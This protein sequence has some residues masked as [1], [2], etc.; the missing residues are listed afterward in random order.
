MKD[1]ILVVALSLTAMA[2]VGKYVRPTTQDRV[3]STPEFIARGGYLVNSVSSCG[4]CHT[5]RIG[6]NWLGGERT[7]AF[8]AGG[9]VFDDR[10]MGMKIAAPNITQDNETGIG[11]WT[12]DEIIRGIRD[13]VRKDGELMWPPMPFSADGFGAMSDDDVRAMVAYLRTV[14]P[15]KNKVDRDKHLDMPFMFKVVRSFG[16]L[17]HK[18]A[19]DVK[20]PP[21]A[22]KKAYGAYLSRVGLCV[23]CHS[24]TKTG[25]DS[26]DN[27]FGGSK[28]PFSE[29]EF[30]KVWARNLTPDP[31]TGLGKFTA[32]QI[33]E[34]LKT[35]RRLDGKPMAL[36]MSL[37]I[38][39]VSTWTDDDLD[40]LVTYLTSV[41]A[42]KHKV[43][44]R[45]L[46]P[47]AKKLVGE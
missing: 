28:V 16:A 20:A 6:G 25:P 22:D 35:G 32:A 19:K 23:D 17:H 7:D 44:D 2:C 43:P 33:K 30:G 13:G 14:P 38:P 15:V 26:E 27:L 29:P 37:L 24:M 5:P 31:E 36:P 12:D 47:D 1:C 21:A 40:A 45:E 11:T 41:A 34:A 18:P 39:H 46:T 9:S 8:L 4:A 42:I 10:G 3:P